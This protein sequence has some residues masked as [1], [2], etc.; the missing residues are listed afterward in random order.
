MGEP[1][2]NADA[3]AILGLGLMGGSLGLALRARGFRGRVAGYAR[4]AEVR[5]EALRRGAADEV[6][7]R[8]EAAAR[9]A[10]VV[11]VCV[12][13]LEIPALAAAAAPA[14][15]PSAAVTDVGSTKAWVADRVRAALGAAAGRFVGSHPIAG[16][17]KQGL[18]AAAPGLYENATVVVT[19]RADGSP[20][21]VSRVAALWRF[22][23]ARVIQ[24]TPDDHD[25]LLARTSHLPHLTAAVLAAVAGRGADVERYGAFCGTGFRDTTRVADGSPEVWHDI[26]RTNRD[27]LLEEMEAFAGRWREAVE[28]LRREDFAALRRALEE[29][30]NARRALL[31]GG[32][33]GVRAE[34][35]SS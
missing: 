32:G 8:P 12:P 25:R 22:V 26:V 31:S 16:S 15:S 24:L 35:E 3:V 9:G 30:R 4:R 17:E 6:F 1:Q 2:Q 10:G 23:G 7:D 34:G 27:A 5:A 18:D 14:L 28:A 20:E 13:V 33:A 21:A 29:G 19:P 11:V